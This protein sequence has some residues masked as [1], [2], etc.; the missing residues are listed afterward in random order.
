MP[1]AL[2]NTLVVNDACMFKPPGRQQEEAYVVTIS[3]PAN[4]I[5]SGICISDKFVI[6]WLPTDVVTVIDV[7]GIGAVLLAL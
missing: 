1:T 2:V 7:P 3:D 6:T 4:Q 5:F